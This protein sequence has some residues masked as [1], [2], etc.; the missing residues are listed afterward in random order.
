M[1]KPS[2]DIFI[3]AD[4]PASHEHDYRENMHAITHGSNNLML[5]ACDQKIEHLNEDFYGQG[6][7]PEANDPERLFKIAAQ[8]RIGAFASQLGLI[9]RWGKKYNNVNYIVKINSKTN[10]VKTEQRDPMSSILWSVDDVIKFKKNSKLNIRGIGLT[11][12]LGS[13]YES[14]MLASTAQAIFNAHQAGL[15]TIVW[16]YPRGKSVKDEHNGALIAGAAGVAHALGTDFAKINPPAS[17]QGTTSVQWLAVAAQAAGNTKLICSGG[18][19]VDETTFLQ[20]LYEQIHTGKTAGNATGRNIHGHTLEKA[21]AM[22]KAISAITIDGKT[23]KEAEKL[24]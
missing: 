24:L 13:E 20:E 7:S 23:A 4:V 6:I 10:L 5:F 9:A 11:L 8:G 12:Y 1:I 19:T 22:T 2:S 16:M 18:K 14:E 15:I 17:S 3:P 21:V